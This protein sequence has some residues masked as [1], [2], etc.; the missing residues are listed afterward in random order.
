MPVNVPPNLE[1]M[2][3]KPKDAPRPKLSRHAAKVFAY[4]RQS[5]I[6]GRRMEIPGREISDYG[7]K[8]A[9]DALRSGRLGATA[10]DA[11]QKKSA[12]RSEKRESEAKAEK[13]RKASAMPILI[14]PLKL[15]RERGA[16]SSDGRYIE[17]LWIPAIL[18]S[19]GALSQPPGA[20]PWIPRNYLE[21]IGRDQA[22]AVGDLEDVD[23]FLAETPLPQAGDWAVYWRY[24]DSFFRAVS[25]SSITEWS[26]EGYEIAPDSIVLFDSFAAGGTGNVERMYDEILDGRRAPGLAETLTGI[27]EPKRR[28]LAKEG[29]FAA[30][31]AKRHLGQ[32]SP[33][34]SLAV[35]Q[36]QAVHEALSLRSG[37]IL[38]VTGPPGTGKTTLIQSLAASL[39]INRARYSGLRPPVVVVC[40]ATNQAVINVIDSFAKADSGSGPLAGRWLPEITSHATFCS[41]FSKAEESDIPQL[42]LSDGTGFS[43]AVENWDYYT[44]AEE[45]FLEQF[46]KYAFKTK[47]V[48]KAAAYL[49]RE[50]NYSVSA[51]KKKIL[52]VQL[53]ELAATIT[54][55]K[56]RPASAENLAK[57]L[58]GLDT[59]ER[60]TA[61]RAAT[62]YWEARWLME[63]ERLLSKKELPMRD[64]KFACTRADWERRAMITPCFVATFSTVNRFFGRERG[65]VRL[66]IDLLI[67]DEAGQVSPELG[68]A[69]FSLADRGVVIGDTEQLE[70]VWNINPAN[71]AA[72]MTR[73]GLI[74]NGDMRKHEEF[75]RAG[76]AASGSSLM[77]R[78]IKVCPVQDHSTIGVFLAEHR[79]SVKKIVEFANALSYRGRLLPMRKEPAAR[80]LPPFGFAHVRGVCSQAGKSRL[81]RIE[82]ESIAGWI[83]QN[84]ERLESHY[85]TE[86]GKIAAVLTP[87]VAQSR[88]LRLLLNRKYPGMT[89]GTVNSLQGAERPVVLFSPVYDR[90]SRQRGFMFDRSANL[91]N[92]AVT[93]AQDSFIVFGDME[94]F[95]PE[96]TKPSGI[97]ARFLF[98]DP[99]N[100]IVDVEPSPLST[101]AKFERLSTLD[102]HREA[103]YE[104]LR[105]ASR[106]VLIVSPSISVHALNFDQLDEEIGQAIK[107][108][109][110]V[111]VYTDETLDKEDN[112]EVREQASLG[113][114]MLVKAGAELFVAGRIH[115]KALAIDE[116]ELIEGSFNWLSAVRKRG[117]SNQKLE[118]SLRYTGSRATEEIRALK[119]D[120]QQRLIKPPT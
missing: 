9:I 66:P 7:I 21:P 68:A 55:A 38:S 112:G 82:A 57:L 71:D 27:K 3:N 114:Q 43:A 69:Q 96:Q 49:Q 61:F 116:S 98:E 118:V 48:P 46:A 4:W 13:A 86:I 81:N 109:I 102:Q 51:I 90:T 25:G 59:T 78:A 91:L 41:S 28:L 99:Q 11:L 5:V 92:V 36:R 77:R 47:S 8:V 97:L 17:P 52:S 32:F 12:E 79:R 42:E 31:R 100:E 108:G 93:R 94:I 62:H 104:A 111:L 65:G 2:K 75:V 40:S 95:D 115:N 22:F 117:S 6:D 83:E 30:S 87:F 106:E 113:R 15:E 10:V 64:G 18:N 39:W 50:M 60:F 103:L 20:Y 80:V 35:T 24:C 76:I 53:G 85:K 19:A 37:E 29:F 34:F 26:A 63:I 89:I 16:G 54:R 45:R 72:N 33:A 105:S 56:S 67:A 74:K 73:H 44:L 58:S 70:P 120:L 14:A 110:R 84:R 119:N 107:R 101:E 23:H 88:Q 1:Q